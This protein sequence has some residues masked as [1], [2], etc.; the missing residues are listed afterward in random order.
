IAC[1]NGTDALELALWALGVKP[2][3]EVITDAHTFAAPA[4]AIIRLGEVHH[5]VD[6]APDTLLM[7]LNLAEGAVTPRTTAILPVHLYGNCVDMQSLMA[8]ARRH[9]LKV[10]EDAAQAHGAFV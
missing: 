7:D 6:V 10:V 3:D 8:I 1:G 5:F 2:G 9:R 4:E